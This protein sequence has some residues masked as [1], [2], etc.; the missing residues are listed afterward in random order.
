MFPNWRTLVHQLVERDTDADQAKEIVPRLAAEFGLD[1]LIQAAQDRAGIPSEEFAQLLSTELYANVRRTLIK[2]D[3]KLF[4]KGLAAFHPGDM[5]PQMWEKVEAIMNSHFPGVSAIELSKIVV[6]SSEAGIGPAAILS[7]NAEPLLYALINC[8]TSAKRIYSPKAP[9]DRITRSLSNRNSGRIPYVFCHGLL[10]IEGHP[11][12]DWHSIDKL[13]FSEPDYLQVANSGFTWQSSTFFECC[14]SRSVVFIGLSL[15]D[16]NLR[17]WLGIMHLNRLRE[18]K[19]I[20][21][22]TTT[23]APHYWLRKFPEIPGE[24][25]WIESAVAH[26]GVRL[27]WLEQWSDLGSF[28]RTMLGL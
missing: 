1:V 20:G 16:P 27:V 10:P 5:T 22:I 4:R 15:S 23:S 26:L 21:Q 18:L 2:S 11:S 14:M 24:K 9:L 12:S 17:R 8:R 19:S 13:V 7:F 28:L 6:E 3:W 25:K